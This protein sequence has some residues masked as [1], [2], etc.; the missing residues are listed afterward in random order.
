MFRAPTSSEVLTDLGD[1]IVFGIGRAVRRT[2]NDLAEYRDVRPGWVASSSER[3]LASW[4]HDRL[5]VHL[6]VQVE[7]IAEVAVI[8]E[9]P[10][11]EFYVG[12]RYRL[13]AK[14]HDHEGGVNSYPTTTALDF[15]GENQTIPIPTL[16]EVRLTAGYEWHREEREIGVPLLALHNSRAKVVWTVELP[17][18]EDG[19][20]GGEVVAPMTPRPTGPTFDFDA[21]R[22][23][24]NAEGQG[25]E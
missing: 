16:E 3:G 4:I 8:D 24:D 18:P 9:E 15:Y 7:G 5:W 13:R 22:T 17:E 14:R 25:E 23:G 12:V 20:G 19:Q 6:M 1:K 2:R 11:R 10:T 21:G